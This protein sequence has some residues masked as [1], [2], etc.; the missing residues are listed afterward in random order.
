MKTYAIITGIAIL[1]GMII[2][3]SMSK[4]VEDRPVSKKAQALEQVYNW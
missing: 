1:T 4:A 3:S 2:I